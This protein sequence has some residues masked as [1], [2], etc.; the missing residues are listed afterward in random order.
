MSYSDCRSSLCLCLFPLIK[1]VGDTNNEN[2]MI[3]LCVAATCNRV[4]YHDFHHQ[5]HLTSD[6]CHCGRESRRKISQPNCKR[7]KS[8]FACVVHVDSKTMLV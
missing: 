5:V 6:D 7:S 8:V 1:A 2:E 3:F 4:C